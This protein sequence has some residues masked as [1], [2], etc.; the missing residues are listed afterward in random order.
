MRRASCVGLKEWAVV[1][2]ALN[3]GRQIL[4]FR[5]GGIA[6]AGGQF[7]VEQYEFFLYPTFLHQ[8]KQYIRPDFHASFTRIL[9]EGEAFDKVRIKSY[10]VVE[11]VIQATDLA[12]LRKLQPYHIWNPAYVDLRYWYKPE[13]PLYLCLLQV[14]RLPGPVE[15]GETKRYRGCRSWVTLDFEIDTAGCAPVLQGAEFEGRARAIRETLRV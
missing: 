2:E 8:D 14:H 4:L 9:R 1:V 6:E 12:A 5:K 15:F 7:R 10:A 11:E 3:D 13:D